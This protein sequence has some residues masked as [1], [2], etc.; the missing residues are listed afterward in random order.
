MSCGNVMS[1]GNVTS[2]GIVMS[3]GNVMS[4]GNVTSHGMSHLME[5]HV[6]WKSLFTGNLGI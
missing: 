4:H 6:L 5:C 1:H 3:C 2:H